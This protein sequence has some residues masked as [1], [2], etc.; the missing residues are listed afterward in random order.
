MR[1][2][3]TQRYTPPSHNCIGA[4]TIAVTPAVDS[5]GINAASNGGVECSP[6]IE[7]ASDIEEL[8]HGPQVGFQGGLLDLESRAWEILFCVEQQ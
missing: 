7:S 4:G 8:K 3:Y 5:G 2:G 1:Q 6:R